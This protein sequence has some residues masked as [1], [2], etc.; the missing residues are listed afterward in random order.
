MNL[1]KCLKTCLIGQKTGLII[2]YIVFVHAET[3]SFNLLSYW[4]MFILLIVFGIVKILL[5][6]F[7]NQKYNNFVTGLSVGLSVLII[8]F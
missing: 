2:K 8:L 5:K 3:T 7:E 1:T 4:I 6:K